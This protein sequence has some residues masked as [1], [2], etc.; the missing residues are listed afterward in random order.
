MGRNHRRKTWASQKPL[1]M[2]FKIKTLSSWETI[3]ESE[4]GDALKFDME[5]AELLVSDGDTDGA[6]AMLDTAVK[7]IL[8]MNTASMVAALQLRSY[9][10]LQRGYTQQALL[11]VNEA[12]AQNVEGRC[13]FCL[14]QLYNI[15][16][17]LLQSL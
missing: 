10:H 3:E 13:C 17:S 5:T 6:L 16:T 9:V 7:S 11:D 2:E 15:Y 4:D 12:F 1:F 14:A 8:K